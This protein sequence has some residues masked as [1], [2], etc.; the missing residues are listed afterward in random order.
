[1]SR[2]LLLVLLGA[3]LCVA[4]IET[5]VL[6]FE[7][8][9][10]SALGEAQS[11][12]VQRGRRVAERL[13]CFA[14]H[15]PGGIHPIPNLGN[16]DGSVPGWSGGT[17]MMYNDDPSDVASWIL[18]G[19]P[20]AHKVSSSALLAMPAYRGVISRGELAD[21]LAYVFTVQRYG[22]LK[23]QQAQRGM[24]VALRAGCFG[25]HG[26]EGRGLVMDP[27]S[28][29]GYIPPWT[30]Q[31][32]ADLVHDKR[33]LREWILDGVTVR[34]KRDPLARGVLSHEVIKMPAFKGRLSKDDIDALVAYIGWVRG[35]SRADQGRRIARQALKRDR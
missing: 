4:V 21:L 26:E 13:G 29:K 23:N 33:E 6:V 19:H 5:A 14:C 9:R 27:G 32:F 11:T 25:C 12:P 24:Q 15:G 10:R 18:D 16:K 17:W 1:M 22:W 30:S 35:H 2:K 3:L 7:N 28:L 8:F 20:P 34:F 31:D